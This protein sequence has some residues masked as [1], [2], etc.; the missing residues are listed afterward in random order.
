[1]PATAA[2]TPAPAAPTDCTRSSS[3][4]RSARAVR[5]DLAAHGVDVVLT[6]D[7][8]ATLTLRQR[9]VA[10]NQRGADLFV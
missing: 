10:A 7:R 6:R 8:D 3:R 4:W 1:M 2:P 5:D 9:V